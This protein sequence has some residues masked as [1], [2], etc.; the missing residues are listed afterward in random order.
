MGTTVLLRHTLP[1]GTW[2]YDWL[3]EPSDDAPALHSFRVLVRIDATDPPTVFEAVPTQPHRPHYLTYE[4][5]VSGDR[6]SVSR[7]ARGAI[8]V[9]PER[10]GLLV[11]LDWGAGIRHYRGTPIEG[12]R[13]RFI[14]V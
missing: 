2:H 8:S 14:L 12:G 5:P 9:S 6:G 13:W 11:Q 4:G 7:V 10:D 3:F 1:D